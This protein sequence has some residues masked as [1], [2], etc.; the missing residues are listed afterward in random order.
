MII[1][2]RGANLHEAAKM[3][4]LSQRE[5]LKLAQHGL[6]EQMKLH[7]GHIMI[8]LRSIETYA[9]RNGLQLR[10]EAA[11]RRNPRTESYTI[12]EA[13]TKL[14]LKDEASVHRLIQ[15]NKLSARMEQG[16]YKVSGESLYRYIT[17]EVN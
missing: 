6:L 3:M 15:T 16:Q 11:G 1:D 5:V 9:R 7:N 13:Q 12:K 10:Y 2:S 17:G 4:G 14:G 8:S